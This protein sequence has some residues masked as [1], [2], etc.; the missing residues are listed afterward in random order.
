MSLFMKVEKDNIRAKK[1]GEVHDFISDLTKP[2]TEKYVYH[3]TTIEALFNGIVY[4]NSDSQ[5]LICLWAT[6]MRC[7]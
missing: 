5:G 7:I 6:I 4:I 1:L 3:Y 2:V